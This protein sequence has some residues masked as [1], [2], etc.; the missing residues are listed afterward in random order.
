[1]PLFYKIFRTLFIAAAAARPKKHSETQDV[2]VPERLIDKKLPFVGQILKTLFCQEKF[3]PI[4][5]VIFG[6]KDC[7]PI[8]TCFCRHLKTFF[9]KIF[10]AKDLYLNRKTVI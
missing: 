6:G 2:F 4:K 8:K 9:L 5:T 10:Y 3:L 7:F 1:L